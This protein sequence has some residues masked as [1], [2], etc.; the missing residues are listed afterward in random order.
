MPLNKNIS[1]GRKIYSIADINLEINSGH[2][3]WN[4]DRPWHEEIIYF[5]LVDRFHD[6]KPRKT[7]EYIP[8]NLK[9]EQLT[10]RLGGTLKGI[11]QHIDYI[12]DLGCTTL[13]I[14]PV[15]ENENKDYH[16]YATIN[17]LNVDPHL[18]TL[19]DFKELV[20]TAHQA[21]IRVILDIVLNHTGNV[22]HYEEDN[23]LYDGS[24]YTFKKWNSPYYP[25]PKELRNIRLY[26]RMGRINNW[27]DYPETQEGDIF[28]LKK[29]QTNLSPRGKEVLNILI[30]VYKFWIKETDVDGFRIDTMKHMDALWIKLFAKEVKNYAEQIGKK[31]FFIFGE[32]IGDDSL[33]RQYVDETMVG[34]IDTVL[35]FP[36][37]F[38]WADVIAGN[39]KIE[40]LY[41]LLE[42]RKNSNDRLRRIH[43]LENHDQ[44]G[45]EIKSRAAIKFST[46]HQWQSAMAGLFFMYGIPCLY[47]GCEQGLAG[48]GNHDAY[49]REPLFSIYDDSDF[50]KTDTKQYQYIKFLT[51]VYKKQRFYEY[52]TVCS[53]AHYLAENLKEIS[54][55]NTMV[56]CREK[57]D[58]VLI[59]VCNIRNEKE[60]I[61]TLNIP[62][63]CNVHNTS[64]N[65]LVGVANGFMVERNDDNIFVKISLHKD[66]FI[67]FSIHSH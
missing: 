11:T 26:K 16:G 31:S 38:L 13:W 4:C 60:N 36:F 46:E 43:F 56:F 64:V 41:E 23:P 40:L 8:Q 62:Q 66:Q 28:E 5:L 9:F 61:I 10:S 24:A 54:R 39:K 30:S 25:L 37:Y 35:D 63:P 53:G 19:D 44:I 29:L 32:L 1:S 51:D 47:Y 14:S 48:Q 12:K 2:H 21:D 15:L 22:W 59:F 52:G 18:G 50:L 17:F 27:D 49:M 34:C 7:V 42:Q 55:N 45:E 65:K 67:I 58:S 57:A 3:C 20:R 33:V 6:A